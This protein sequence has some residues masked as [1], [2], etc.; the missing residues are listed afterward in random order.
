MWRQQQTLRY[1]LH[2]G[3]QVSFH[4]LTQMISWYLRKEGLIAKDEFTSRVDSN[5]IFPY[6]IPRLNFKQIFSRGFLFIEFLWMLNHSNFF[7]SIQLVQMKLKTQKSKHKL[8]VSFNRN[9]CQF[10]S[11][12]SECFFYFYLNFWTI[13]LETID[14]LNKSRLYHARVHQTCHEMRVNEMLRVKNR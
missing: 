4:L 14:F 5:K 8:I 9:V 11:W 1:I 10:K 12:F 13:C 6:D 3:K 2:Y 7:N